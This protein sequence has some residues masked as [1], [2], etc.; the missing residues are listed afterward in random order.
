MRPSP[1]GEGQCQPID[2]WI[3]ASE[4]QKA[5]YDRCQR[6]KLRNQEVEVLMGFI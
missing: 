5:E 6:V 3:S 2:D 4:P 1:K